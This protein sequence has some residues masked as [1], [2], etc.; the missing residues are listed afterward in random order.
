[1]EVAI[2]CCRCNFISNICRFLFY[3][4]FCFLIS[5]FPLAIISSIAATF[6]PSKKSNYKF[7]GKHTKA[8]S[9]QPKVCL[10]FRGSDLWVLHMYVCVCEVIWIF[11]TNFCNCY[12]VDASFGWQCVWLATVSFRNVSSSGQN[13]VLGVLQKK[14]EISIT[15]VILVN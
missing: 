10:C 3:L 5:I 4:L 2:D 11:C 9:V 12:F 8:A 15:Q 14:V 1:M 13:V 7:V 6:T